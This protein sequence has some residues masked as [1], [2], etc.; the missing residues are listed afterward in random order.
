MKLLALI[1]AFDELVSSVTTDVRPRAVLDDLLGHGVIIIDADDRVQL[2]TCGV[3]SPTRGR[4][5]SCSTSLAICMD[6]LAAAVSNISAVEVP[7]FLDRSVHYDRL[8]PA[9]VQTYARTGAMRLL[10]DVNRLAQELTEAALKP[11][12]SSRSGSIS[13]SIC[14]R[15]MNARRPAAVRHEPREPR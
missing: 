8:T 10:P 14:L 7:P 6:H 11:N 13:G 4:G 9:Q 2:D 3:H 1:L 12:R 5:A 15:K